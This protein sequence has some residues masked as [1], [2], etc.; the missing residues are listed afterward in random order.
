[1]RRL[2][3][4]V[5]VLV[6]SCSSGEEPDS[7]S[8]R[9]GIGTPEEISECLDACEACLEDGVAP[10]ACV[11]DLA[12]CI[13]G[14]SDAPV[15]S[16]PATCRTVHE[17]CLDR[18]FE[19]E[20]CAI[21]RDDCV[22]ADGDPWPTAEDCVA[23]EGLCRAYGHSPDE[24]RVVFELC[25]GL[26]IE[27]GD[28]GGDPAPG[29]ERCDAALDLCLGAG[30]EE[31]I[32]RLVHDDCVAAGGADWPDLD[33][34]RR[35]YELCLDLGHGD[36]ECRVILETCEDMAGGAPPEPPADPRCDEVF[37]VCRDAGYPA[38]LCD[39]FRADC[40][41][42]GD[43]PWPGPGDCE[44]AFELCRT[45]GAGDEACR[46]LRDTCEG[47]VEEPPADPPGD[48]ARCEEVAR[49]CIDWGFAPD[50]CDLV[51]A[52]CLT[53]DP[54]RWPE[55]DDC[56][57]AFEVCRDTGHDDAQCRMIRDVCLSL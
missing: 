21:V 22:A 46:F 38:G 55:P 49:L 27:P 33:D 8:Q 53:S 12:T 57:R 37:D 54:D 1:M 11:A 4:V 10:E 32:C 3:I 15:H 2:S 50:L 30:F 45:S 36:D 42:A 44:M 16:D 20:L 23:G 17:V 40:L 43:E 29:H 7:R 52:D 5:A 13:L 18:G 9:A 48:P 47:L 25:E 31:P 39:T 28:D 6:V 26:G 34:C 24:C 35:G 51:S 14:D 41:A 56:A 19:P